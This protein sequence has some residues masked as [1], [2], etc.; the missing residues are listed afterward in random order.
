MKLTESW[1]ASKCCVKFM[2]HAHNMVFTKISSGQGP[3]LSAI[4]NQGKYDQKSSHHR[5]RIFLEK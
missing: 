1:Q 3:F 4:N 5:V 2:S